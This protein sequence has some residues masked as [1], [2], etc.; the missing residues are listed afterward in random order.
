MKKPISKISIVCG[1]GAETYEPNRDGI[2]KIEVEIIQIAEDNRH[3]YYIG[4][5]KDGDE[6][7]R[8]SANTPIVVERF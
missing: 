7:L 1:Q 3:T 2:I 4:R 8:I 5:D 6:I